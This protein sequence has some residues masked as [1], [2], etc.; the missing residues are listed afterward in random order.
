MRHCIQNI[1]QL[2][3]DDAK[4]E[5]HKQIDSALQTNHPINNQ[6]YITK[7]NLL[8][9]LIKHSYGT[10]LELNEILDKITSESPLDRNEKI[11]Y[12]ILLNNI[13]THLSGYIGWDS[14]TQKNKKHKQYFFRK[15]VELP[16]EQ[17]FKN[18]EG[19]QQLSNL[20]LQR[21]DYLKTINF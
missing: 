1:L 19:Y 21:L 2:N 20:F 5:I 13:Q 7:I 15:E 4:K 12:G 18:E 16:F 11:K 3:Y 10:T 14:Y 8:Q 9:I 17:K 6:N